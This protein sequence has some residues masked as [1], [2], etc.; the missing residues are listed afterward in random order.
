M[1]KKTAGLSASDLMNPN[2]P[3]GIITYATR[4]WMD[5]DTRAI[6]LVDVSRQPNPAPD[7]A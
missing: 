1:L 6:V 7:A 5:Q 2:T 4:N 3:I